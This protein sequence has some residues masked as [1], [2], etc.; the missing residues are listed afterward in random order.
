MRTHYLIPN[1]SDAL[2]G[3]VVNGVGM[4]DV[5]PHADYPINNHPTGYM[6]D[7]ERGRI[8]QEYQLLYIVKGSGKFSKSSGTYDISQ[9][10]VI[11]LRPGVWHSYKPLK[12]SGWGEFFIGFQ[13]EFVDKFIKL[14]F[15]AEEQIFNIGHNRTLIDLYQQAIDVAAYD[16]P[17]AQQ[18]LSGIVL[19]MLSIVNFTV[20]NETVSTN[21]LDQIVERAK[22]IMQEKVLQ[23][24]DL[25]ALAAQLN[26]SYSWFRKI[27]RDYTGHPP[28][29]YFILLKLRHAQFLLANTQES[30]KEIAFS[31]GF[32]S[33]EH[34]FTTFKRVTGYTPNA[35]RK[36]STPDR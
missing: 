8:L 25:E 14:S 26:I 3:C 36:L 16:R 20:R 33:I 15:P 27:F 4:Q 22:A 2:Y 19:H 35:Y 11:L 24:I 29:K 18:L 17:G 21:H 7:T 23:N 34:F 6:F 5:E 31:L 30:I 28:A 10:T 1:K 9:G 32:K 13:G 12:E